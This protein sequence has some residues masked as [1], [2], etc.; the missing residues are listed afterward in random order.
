M[1][2]NQKSKMLV[3]ALLFSA[4]IVAF[5]VDL[6]GISL[7]QWIGVAVG[8]LAAYH[9]VTH[10]N[11]VSAVTKRLFG[12]TSGKARLYYLLDATI[13]LGSILMLGSGLVIST[14]FNL[15]LS[16]YDVWREVHIVSSI[17]TLLVTVL[18]LG[19]HGRWIQEAVK[20]VF[21]PP[22]APRDVRL[23][24]RRAFLGVMGIVGLASFFAL[25]NA[26]KGLQLSQADPV[27]P[28][29]QAETTPS[30]PAASVSI[31]TDQPVAID[32]SESILT[33]TAATATAT[34][35]QNSVASA[36]S[37]RC[38]RGCSYPG[39]CRKYTDANGNDRCDLGECL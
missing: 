17:G 2:T 32:Q 34:Q 29:P 22:A 36:C 5:F 30:T 21:S 39:R 38:P 15:P 11:W 25:S 3:D 4:F 18:K 28:V 37:V 12:H 7:H 24:N 33:V 6:T 31:A 10:W 8:A 35:T 20:N 1:N 27:T 19:L 16:N 9:L 23:S 13:L 26:V 14:W